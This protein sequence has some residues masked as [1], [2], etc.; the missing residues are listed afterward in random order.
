MATNSIIEQKPPSQ[1]Y[2]ILAV[3]QKIIFVVSN[4]TAVA[5][6]TRV[7]FV[8]KVH[9]SENTYPDLSTTTDLVGTFK[10]TPNNAGVGIYDFSNVVEN[11][12]SANNLAANGSSYKGTTTSNSF[13]PPIQLIDKYSLNENIVKYMAIEFAVEYKGAT[14]SSGTS[15]VNTVAIQAGTERNSRVYVLFNGYIKETDVLTTGTGGGLNRLN[16]AFDMSPFILRGGSSTKKL[17]TNAPEIQ[18]ANIN[19]YGTMSFWDDS[20]DPLR[21]FTLTYYD[22]SDSL[23]GIDLIERTTA[24]GAYDSYDVSA[25]KQL[26][27]IGCFPGNLQNWSSTFKTLVAAGTVQGGYYFVSAVDFAADTMTQTYRINLNC[28][29][30]KG[31]EPIRL[32][33]LNQWGCWDYYTFTKKSTKTF[34][35]QGTTYDQLGGTWNESHYRIDSFKG[36][37][38]TFRVNTTE[39]IQINTDFLIEEENVMFEELINSPEVYILKE[40]EADA[41]NSAL[42]QYVTPTRIIT[43]TQTRKTVANDKLIQYTFEIEKSKKLRTQSI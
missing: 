5:N 13:K 20:G 41:S 11:Y 37:K 24:N 17:L 35:T 15:D 36:G 28:P 29:T 12:V 14:D 2:Q 22:S 7:K 34:T 10:T 33:W 38:K 31:Y 8:A 3:G 18:Y 19:D 25:K 30:L 21:R 23:L 4:Q 43:T 32:C 1:I 6:E 39:K 26:K 9:I 42:N 16:F 27:H 40:Y